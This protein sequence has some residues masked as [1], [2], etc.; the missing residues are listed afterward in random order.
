MSERAHKDLAKQYHLSVEQVR[1]LMQLLSDE[2]SAPFILRY[3]KDLAANLSTDDLDAL[4]REARRLET[5]ER[6][7]R[8]LFRKL[9]E[10]GVLGE[11][12]GQK[13]NSAETTS[14]LID[15]YVPF[16][17][18]K[19]SRSRLA[20]AQ[21]LE[22][23]AR[24][25][26][27]QEDPIPLLSEAAA[28]YID[29]EKG[30]TDVGEVLE[31]AFHIICDW[32]AEEKSH[33]DRQREVLRKQGA[34]ASW[35]FKKS[36]P[37][38]LRGEF[39]DYLHFEA[40]L[41]DVHPY[42]VLCMMRG[43]RLKILNYGVRPSLA[44]M[45]RAAADLY[46]RGGAEQFNQIDVRFHETQGAPKG[47]ALGELSGAEFLYWCIRISLTKALVP[48]LTREVERQLRKKAEELGA[49]II[50]RNL[51][52]Q[53]MVR[54]LKGHR[55]LGISPGYRTG[56]KL[57]AL[58][59]NGG[60]LETAI[61]YPHTPRF[62]SD[63]AK[64]EIVALIQRH[65]LDVAAIGEGTAW[66]ETERLISE[67]ISESCPEFRYAVVSEMGAQAYAGSS[68][69]NRELRGLSRPLQTAV[70][71][72]RQLLDPLAELTKVG[73]RDLCSP[74]YVKEVEDST[75]EKTLRRAAEECVAEVGPDLN[76]SPRSVLKYVPGLDS[77]TALEVVKY[78]EQNGAF[79]NR[80]RLREVPKVDEGIWRGAVGFVKVSESENP[81][82]ATR[83]HPDDYPVAVAIL[84]QLGMSPED[85]REKEGRAKIASKRG[86]VKFAELEK[87]FNVHY[88]YLKDMLDELANPW[89][90]PRLN[91]DGPM[92]RRHELAFEDLEPGQTLYGTV[93]KVVGFGAFVDVGVSEDGLVHISEL[94]DEFV[95]S[96]YD[97]VSTGDLVKVR[98]VEVDAEKRRI[99]LSMR[100][101]GSRRVAPKGERTGRK[102]RPSRRLPVGTRQEGVAVAQKVSPKG[103]IR[104][105]QSTLGKESWRVKKVAAFARKGRAEEKAPDSGGKEVAGRKRRQPEEKHRPR[106][107][108][109]DELLDKLDFA[110]IERR[111]EQKQ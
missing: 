33:R 81:L 10:Q 102:R 94:A 54:P 86:E 2:V 97:V 95:P 43:K 38:R 58:D 104:A 74:R 107:A 100:S 61:V 65:E 55:V 79:A 60:V 18:R 66:Q 67:V 75:L 45:Y 6:E 39:R 40:P 106:P 34:L 57:A 70:A 42:H 93:R 44:G 9:E 64:A 105:P 30:L 52:S 8:R 103:G 23:L 88:L 96:P 16:R 4:R 27:M 29:P 31:G 22:G 59:E 17:P 51:R 80:S 53:L 101:E 71:L 26:F 83:I 49:D 47:A 84:E 24:Q 98:V 62:E 46:L 37:R 85:L 92:L 78:R 63:E 14:E 5:L 99:A 28:A 87:Q 111:G 41:Q 77:T 25:V 13:L 110:A 21:G 7:R 50:K 82:D 56:C 68:L 36:L 48:I 12:L 20:F 108:R 89:P 109:L 3:R 1:E 69:A 19:R 90:D 35:A 73:L 32:M 15:Y 72:G 76:S 91:E 11:E